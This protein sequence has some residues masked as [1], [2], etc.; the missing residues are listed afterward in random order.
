[1]R[2]MIDPDFRSEQPESVICF[3][4]GQMTVICG[5]GLSTVVFIVEPRGGEQLAR[6]STTALAWSSTCV[7]S[8][9]S[10]D[11]VASSNDINFD[12]VMLLL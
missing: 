12:V 9:V 5:V 7:N 8:N 2:R 1:M 4:E 3:K 10:S 11:E 6:A